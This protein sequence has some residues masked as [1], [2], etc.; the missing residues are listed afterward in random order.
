MGSTRATEGSHM[1]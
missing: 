1:K